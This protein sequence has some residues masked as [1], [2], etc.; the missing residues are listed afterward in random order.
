MFSHDIVSGDVAANA[1]GIYKRRNGDHRVFLLEIHLLKCGR[2]YVCFDVNFIGMLFDPQLGLENHIVRKNFAILMY[3]LLGQCY[4]FHCWYENIEKKL[5]QH[6]KYIRY[7]YNRAKQMQ[8]KLERLVLFEAH[9][10]PSF[11]HV[12]SR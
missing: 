9:A 12:S 1:V 7:T 4:F 10:T 11:L 2:V 3:I 6:V 8:M 5:L